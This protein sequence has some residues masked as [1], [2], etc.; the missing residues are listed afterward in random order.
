[1]KVP[2]VAQLESDMMPKHF[3][4]EVEEVAVGEESLDVEKI[5]AAFLADAT[6]EKPESWGYP[7]ALDRTVDGQKLAPLWCL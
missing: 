5:I 3:L 6:R 2:A 7:H 1:M 4:T